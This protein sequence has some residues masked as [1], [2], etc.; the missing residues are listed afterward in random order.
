MYYLIKY[1]YDGKSFCGFQRNNGDSSVENVILKVLKKYS[2]SEDME[3]AA[4]TDKNV[5]AAGNVLLINTEESI[6]KIMKILNSQIKNM[7]FY[8]YF[9]SIEYINPRHNELKKYSYIISKKY[10]INAIMGTLKKF[11][12]T[13]DFINF[14]RKDNR[15]T[16]RTIENINYDELQDFFLINFYGRSFIWHQI[17]NIMGFALRYYNTDMDP[18]LMESHFSYISK[19]EQLILMNTFST[20]ILWIG[21]K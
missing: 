6:E 4:R 1:G 3:S 7:F 2:I 9:K 5:S 12:G 21:I 11:I 19:P 10:D 13:H 15:N 20:Y 16:I 17:R 8:A 18:F 14:C